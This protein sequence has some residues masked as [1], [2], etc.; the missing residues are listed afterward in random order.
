MAN[1][2]RYNPD[3]YAH[4][5]QAEDSKLLHAFPECDLGLLPDMDEVDD[6]LYAGKTLEDYRKGIKQRTRE[7]IKIRKKSASN[8]DK[9]FVEPTSSK[10]D[11]ESESDE[12]THWLAAGQ[13]I[14]DFKGFTWKKS[15]RRMKRSRHHS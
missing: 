4:D 11:L 3:D 2:Q 5:S 8:N 15:E 13:S 1:T 14:D 12:I 10:A 7:L 6:W 9:L